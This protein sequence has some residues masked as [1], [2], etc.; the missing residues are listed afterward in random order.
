[1]SIA[2][3][4]I[5]EK[6]EKVKPRRP[7]RGRAGLELKAHQVSII[8]FWILAS[9]TLVLIAFALW[10]TFRGLSGEALSAARTFAAATIITGFFTLLA[11]DVEAVAGAVIMIKTR[12]RR[13]IFEVKW[14]TR[15]ATC[16]NGFQPKDIKRAQELIEIKANRLRERIKNGVGGPDKLAIMSLFAMAGAAL[17]TFK[18]FPGLVASVSGIGN[19]HVEI[20]RWSTIAVFAFI[21]G[22]IIAT[23]MM[24]RQLD[25]FTYQLEIIKIHL[26][27][28]N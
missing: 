25:R 16:L 5:L 4:K 15:Q 24:N 22:I 11:A 21:F 10:Q 13:F 14:D 17:S 2:V 3:H 28:Q 27:A 18:E 6:L 26:S 1:M 12:F 9:L 7:K 8:S 23:I 20:L 19:E